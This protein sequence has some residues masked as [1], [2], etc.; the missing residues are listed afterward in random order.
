MVTR[1][2]VT[3]APPAV[4]LMTLTDVLVQPEIVMS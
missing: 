2:S 1:R 3:G 4:L